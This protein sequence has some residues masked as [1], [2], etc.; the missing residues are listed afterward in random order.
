MLRLAPSTLPIIGIGV[1]GLGA[2]LLYRNSGISRLVNS[3]ATFIQGS[4]EFVSGVNSNIQGF[5][6]SISPISDL[7][8]EEKKEV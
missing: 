3:T 5:G 7:S 4:Q 2:Y 1:L 8:E 6:A